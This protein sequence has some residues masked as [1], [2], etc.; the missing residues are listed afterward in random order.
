MFSLVSRCKVPECEFGVNNRDLKYDQPWLSSAIPLENGKFDNCHRYAVKNLTSSSLHDQCNA[1]MFDA[2]IKVP[3]TEYVYASDERNIQT[4]VN[5]KCHSNL[6]IIH[7]V[8]V[9]TFFASLCLF[10][11]FLCCKVQH[12]LCG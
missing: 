8:F 12:S 6:F 9:G 5:R 3:C 7:S 10:P 2:S 1:D 4:E 11:M